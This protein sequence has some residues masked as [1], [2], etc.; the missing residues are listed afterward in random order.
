MAGLTR[1]LKTPWLA[2]YAGLGLLVVSL[3]LASACLGAGWM[4]PTYNLEIQTHFNQ[5]GQQHAGSV[6]MT[7][8]HPEEVTVTI[9]ANGAGKEGF[10]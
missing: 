5:S 7:L 10:A 1:V 6:V 2:A 3:C 8:Q 9:A 4:R